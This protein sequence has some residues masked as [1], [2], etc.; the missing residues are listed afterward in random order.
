MILP[1]FD[2][3]SPTSLDEALSWLEANHTAGVKILAGGTD[4]LVDIRG[5]VIPDSHR[6]RCQE[7]TSRPWQ[8]RDTLK[9]SVKV[10]LALSRIPE[11]RGI[12]RQGDTIRVGAMTTISELERSALIRDLLP[13]LWDG[14]R[15]LGSPLVRNRGTFGG[16]LA[17][18]RPAADTAIPTLALCGMLRLVSTRGERLIDEN[19]FVTGPGRTILAPDEIVESVIFNLS[20]SAED[21]RRGSAYFKLANRK[22]LEISVVGAA[23]AVEFDP[24]GFVVSARVALGAVAPKPLWVPEVGEYLIGRELNLETAQAAA[25]IAAHIAKPISDHRGSREYRLMM[26]EILVRRA[27][28]LSNHRAATGQVEAAA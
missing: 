7:H 22:A 20:L 21:H 13:A 2:Y 12:S 4:L 8:A 5:K 1:K 18:A 15:S 6:P 25:Q 24:V 28:L 11:L 10:L 17:N 27:L 14:A 16:N 23:A 3:V 26:T 9:D 19:D